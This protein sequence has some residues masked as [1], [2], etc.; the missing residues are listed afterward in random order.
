MTRWFFLSLSSP[1]SLLFPLFSCP[2]FEYAQGRL[3]PPKGVHL[4]LSTSMSSKPRPSHQAILPAI[5]SLSIPIPLPSPLCY[6]IVLHCNNKKI[7]QLPCK[8]FACHCCDLTQNKFLQL[9]PSNRQHYHCVF[10]LT[11]ILIVPPLPD[12]YSNILQ[13]Q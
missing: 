11:V 10:F 8:K 5:A 3:A 1:F 9:Q 7:V 2:L 4:K 13:K 6:C 12:L